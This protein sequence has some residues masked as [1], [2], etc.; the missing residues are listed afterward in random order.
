MND[1]NELNGKN[2]ADDEELS[3]LLSTISSAEDALNAI[4]YDKESHSLL[5]ADEPEDE[6]E[7]EAEGDAESNSEPSSETPEADNN[8]Q[9]ADDLDI[10][11]SEVNGAVHNE[12]ADDD[13]ID[14]VLP[15]TASE[16]DN[17]EKTT[18]L[19]N[20][21]NVTES[22]LNSSLPVKVDTENEPNLPSE[23]KPQALELEPQQIS[24]QTPTAPKKTS[25]KRPLKKGKEKKSKVNN[26][27]F[28]GIIITIIILTVSTVIA[29]TGITVGLE[30][31]GIGKS[32]TTIKLNIKD[33]YSVSDI[34]DV[35]YDKGIINSKF[36]FK[37]CV[38][39]KGAEDKIIPGDI[40]LQPAMS[41]NDK[42]NEMMR[43][44]QSFETVDVTFPEGTD[45]YTAAKILKE[46]DVINSV[47]DF[48]YDFNSLKLGYDYEDIIDAKGDKFFAMEGYFYP[49]TYQFYK[50]SDNEAVIS[51]LREVFNLRF[52]DDMKKRADEI[53]LTVDEVLTIASIV[54]L[55]S[56]SVEEMPMIASVFENRIN[57][58]PEN[59]FG[60]YI[61]RLQSDPTS[62]YY[63]D[64][65]I[66]AAQDL[67]NY[68][69]EEVS[70]FKEKY[71]TYER[72]GL[73]VGPICNPG[74]DAINAVL[75]PAETN[76]F[77]FCHD[78]KT[79]QGYFAS[80]LSEHEAN[81]VAAGI[82]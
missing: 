1:K 5:G 32:T 73:P 39:I 7:I 25:A 78:I 2:T 15:E 75:N 17:N 50:E 71:D 70:A 41:Y 69:T 76:Y 44:R 61:A 52:T 6:P 42:I 23:D 11:L 74:I 30:Y 80:T 46:N 58:G 22:S 77:Y 34:A 56:A 72:E 12:S 8:D 79:K 33:D 65:I 37:I 13:E 29:F 55:E 40:E 9:V 28:T 81:L 35:L 54:Q 27:I 49:D 24:M 19:S 3:N 64:V 63:T 26:S 66:P 68:T 57:D 14:E 10:T 21:S 20:V 60:E 43:S 38:D 31:L 47:T 82:N 51:T 36:L 45:L 67:K 16:S 4:N 48:L 18:V 53:G 62:N 59:Q